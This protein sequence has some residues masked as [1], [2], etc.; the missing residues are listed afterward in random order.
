[1]TDD[2][3]LAKLLFLVQFSLPRLCAVWD[4]LIT[5]SRKGKEASHVTQADLEY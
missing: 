1:M 4:T 5:L 3:S 2:S